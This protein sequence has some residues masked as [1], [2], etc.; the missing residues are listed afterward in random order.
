MPGYD[1]SLTAEHISSNLRDYEAGRSGFFSFIVN[2]LDNIV[3]ATYSGETS[4]A[5]DTD[6]IARAQ[7]Y[8]RLNVLKAPVP[9]FSIKTEEYRRGNEIVK[10]A[11]VP[12]WSEGS[13]VVDDV[14]GLDTKAI[15]MAWQNLAYR[16]KQRKGG[17]MIDYKKDCTLVE[18][19]QD[20][21]QV[22][23]WTLYG[24]W[25]NA[26]SEDDFDREN[27]GHRKIT[28]T[29]QYDRAEMNEKDA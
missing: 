15:L 11:G 3:K 17:R 6:K 14:V 8:L 20:Y 24:C 9:H 26:I 23:S 10:F 12:E 1:T 13:I 7:D 29:I 16:V 5:A 28:A 21:E 27:D 4:E 25:I 18:Y 22:R 2:D 19:T